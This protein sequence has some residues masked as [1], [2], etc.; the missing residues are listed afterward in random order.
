MRAITLH[1]PKPELPIAV[2]NLDT[3]FW[4]EGISPLGNFRMPATHRARPSCRRALCHWRDP[5]R[6]PSVRILRP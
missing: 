3:V 6:A 4:P 1:T 2:S 5:A